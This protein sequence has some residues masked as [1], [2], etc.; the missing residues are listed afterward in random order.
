MHLLAPKFALLLS[1][2]TLCWQDAASTQEKSASIGGSTAPTGFETVPP[3]EAE[4]IAEVV[5]LTRQLLQQRYPE[6]M[7][8][9]GVHPKDH[10]CVKASFT[11]NRDIPENYRVGL[12]ATPGK[13][14]DAWIRFSNAT[15]VLAPDIDQNG[16]ASRGMAIKVMGV[17]GPTLLGDASAKTQDFLLINL[18]G[19]AFP[20]VAEYLAVTRIQLADHDNIAAFFAPPLSPERLKTA[21]V[22]KQISET[23]VGNPL[24]IRDFLAAPFLFGRDRVVKFSARPG[25]PA[26]R[27]C[28][29]TRPQ[30]FARS[31]A[32]DARSTVRRSDRVRFP[33]AA[34][35][36]RPVADR[37]RDRRLAGDGGG[38]PERRDD[39]DR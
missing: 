15:P 11:I 12:F 37:R 22:V 38:V 31:D 23:K 18:P 34:A 33:G 2:A 7:A 13:T 28:R 32:E 16:P 4:Q 39:F 29:K 5:S 30:L 14:Y 27:P 6:G 19:F 35:R 1:I 25:L 36:E 17:D 9:R 10:G 24:D 3:G 8:R 26:I 21:I 20:N